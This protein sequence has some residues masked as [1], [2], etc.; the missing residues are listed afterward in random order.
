VGIVIVPPAG[1]LTIETVRPPKVLNRDE[2]QAAKDRERS[3][4]RYRLAKD[5]SGIYPVQSGHD[6]IRMLI[7]LGWLAESDSEDR[8]H[9]AKA[10]SDLLENSAKDF[11]TREN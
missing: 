9:V 5:G 6:V 3:N 2:L 8:R 10:I 1:E 11:L 4:R 7:G